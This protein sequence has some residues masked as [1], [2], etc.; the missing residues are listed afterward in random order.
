M[1]QRDLFQRRY[2]I[3]RRAQTSPLSYVKT[4][5][6]IALILLVLVAAVIGAHDALG[7]HASKAR[8]MLKDHP[9][10]NALPLT[11]ATIKQPVLAF[12]YAWYNPKTWCL[13]TM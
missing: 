13:C 10:I 2:S 3:V 1:T 8:T 4:I 6:T 12:Y 9:I 7:A 11:P 5:C